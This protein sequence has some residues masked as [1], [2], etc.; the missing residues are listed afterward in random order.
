DQTDRVRAG[1]GADGAAV[2]TANVSPVQI[3]AV[4]S[5]PALR[6]RTLAGPTPTARYLNINTARVADVSVRRAL[7]IAFDRAAF[8]EALGGS[9]VAAPSTTILAPTVPGYRSYDAYPAGAHGDP[10]RARQLL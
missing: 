4:Q 1:L 7:N 8:V 10:A 2:M 6:A 9:A 3:A 5:D